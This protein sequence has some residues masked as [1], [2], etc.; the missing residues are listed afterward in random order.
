MKAAIIKLIIVLLL[1]FSGGILSEGGQNETAQTR[2]GAYI[3]S[4]EFSSGYELKNS[5]WVRDRFRPDDK[6]KIIKAGEEDWIVYEFETELEHKDCG[7]IIDE[8]MKCNVDGEFTLNFKT[9]KFSLTSTA[10]YVHS[11][12]RN[13]DPVVL[14]LGTCVKI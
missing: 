2:H 9:M 13:R 7:P 6:Y 4:A 3:C 12:R 14:T 5:R 10:S 8:V 11:T 1:L